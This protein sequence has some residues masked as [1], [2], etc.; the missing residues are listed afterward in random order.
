VDIRERRLIGTGVWVSKVYTFEPHSD[1]PLVDASNFQN[2]PFFGDS[3]TQSGLGGWGNPANDYQVT[4]G[5]LAG[6]HLS[7]PIPHNLRRNFTDLP[8]TTFPVSPSIPNPFRT[9]TSTFTA[10]EVSAAVNGFVGDF[11]G[12]QNFVEGRQV[13]LVN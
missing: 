9:A 7:Y 12:L 4:T 1:Y 10:S 5:A 13:C 3:N 8:W 2:S 11:S 6:F